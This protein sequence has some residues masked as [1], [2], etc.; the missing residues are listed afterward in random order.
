MAMMKSIIYNIK[1]CIVVIATAM[2][3]TSCLEKYPGSAIPTDKSMQ[4]YEDALQINTGIYVEVNCAVHDLDVGRT[5]RDAN[6]L[7]NCEPLAS[8]GLGDISV[9]LGHSVLKSFQ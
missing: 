9:I 1:V 7:I 4:T 6:D 8:E 3:A 2:V 5:N